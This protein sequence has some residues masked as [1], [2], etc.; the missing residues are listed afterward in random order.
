[1]EI[2]IAHTAACAEP[3]RQSANLHLHRCPE[4]SSAFGLWGTAI[5]HAEADYVAVLDLQVPPAPCWRERVRREIERGTP[6]FFGA[7]ELGWKSD[8]V[9]TVGYLCEYAQF[10]A[11][12]R[13][14]LREVPGN[15]L[16][17][18]RELI[19]GHLGRLGFDKTVLL[20]R[21][22]LPP[23]AIEGMPV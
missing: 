11:P 17:G 4:T 13:P 6:L 19:A 16:V 10:A 23:V 5:A 21:L 3:V 1:M 7:V 9:R 20:R 22:A 12:L 2:H 15:N 8:D 18:Q 14:G